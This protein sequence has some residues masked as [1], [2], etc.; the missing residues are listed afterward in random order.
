MKNDE[1]EVKPVEEQKQEE[2]KKHFVLNVQ[3]SN[4]GSK[5]NLGGK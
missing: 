3:D 1:K 5:T 2:E 4:L